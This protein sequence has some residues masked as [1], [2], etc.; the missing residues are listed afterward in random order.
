MSFKKTHWPLTI[1]GGGVSLINLL[2]PLVLVR[3][4]SSSEIGQYKIYFLYLALIP[5]LLLSS[6]IVN[7]L[8]HWGGLPQK[9]YSALQSSWTALVCMS[10]GFLLLGFLFLTPIQR[11]LGWER[12]EA[13][14]LVLGVSITMISNFFDEASIATGRILRGA[15]FSSGFDLIRN[16]SML[17]SAYYFR[18]VISVLWS[19]VIFISIKCAVGALWGFVDKIQRPNFSASS[20]RS[21]FKYAFPVSIASALSVATGYSDQIVLSRLLRAEEFAIYSFGCLLVPPL[22]IFEQSVNKVLIPRMSECF[23]KEESSK[24]K[25]L[26]KNGIAELSWLLIPSGIGLIVFAEPIVRLLFTEK[27]IDAVVFLRVYSITHLVNLLPYDSVARSKGDGSWIMRRLLFFSILS[28]ISVVIG[29]HFY[30]AIGALIALVGCQALMRIS[31]VIDISRTQEWALTEM[32]PFAEW[33]KFYLLSL[34]GATLAYVARPAFHSPLGWFGVMGG[35]FTM[36]YL[37]FTFKYFKKF[38]EF[39]ILP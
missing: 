6:G 17:F 12:V 20:F 5:W 11:L 21:V 30:G 36:I 18:S 19:H 38:K 24:A 25:K 16:L 29:A 26:F 1:L 23:S 32:L 35:I 9:K 13:F 4:L 33:R 15:V 37:S 8:S 7:G 27:F 2:L 34:A 31:S 3:V 10:G 28:T 22:L 39:N 14:L